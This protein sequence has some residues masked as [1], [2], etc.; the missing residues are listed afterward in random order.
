MFR[1]KQKIYSTLPKY[2]VGTVD[3]ET[4]GICG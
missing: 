3:I 1:D 2:V 4:D